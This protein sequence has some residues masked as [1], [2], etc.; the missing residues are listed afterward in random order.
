MTEAKCGPKNGRYL[1]ASLFKEKGWKTHLTQYK[2]LFPILAVCVHVC[3]VVCLTLFDPLD[4]NLPGS[5][6]H[7]IFQARILEWIAIPFSR[8]SS[9]PRD[10]TWLS[11]IAGRLFTV[12][13]TIPECLK[14]KKK[15][16]TFN[17]FFF[18]CYLANC[19]YH[20]ENKFSTLRVAQKNNHLIVHLPYW[21]QICPTPFSGRILL[22]HY[23]AFSSSV[24]SE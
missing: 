2:G 1:L 4:C 5:S 16:V 10:W 11:H 22:R 19:L 18:S 21:L 14:K 3:V 9:R 6:I 24:F 12:W 20:M 13:T 8:G 7:G 17:W 23:L 15:R